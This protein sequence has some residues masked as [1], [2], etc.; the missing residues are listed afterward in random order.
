MTFDKIK[1]PTWAHKF[2]SIF[3]RMISSY[4]PMVVC[5]GLTVTKKL[6]FI[7]YPHKLTISHFA[8]ILILPT[9]FPQFLEEFGVS[10]IGFK[11]NY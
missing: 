3:P 7:Q 5:D 11:E 8:I 2:L 1:P 9:N 10:E 4:C 6:S